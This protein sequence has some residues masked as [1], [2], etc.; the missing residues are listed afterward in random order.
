VHGP[1]QVSA[2]ARECCREHERGSACARC[3][4]RDGP[5]SLV[6]SIRDAGSTQWGLWPRCPLPTPGRPPS[7]PCRTVR[8][9]RNCPIGHVRQCR[10]SRACARGWH[11]MH[12]RRA[13]HAV[14][15]VG[16]LRPVVARWCAPEEP[17][18]VPDR[19][20]PSSPMVLP[21]RDPA[22]PR[23]APADLAFHLNPAWRTPPPPPSRPRLA[24]RRARRARPRGPCS[25]A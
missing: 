9:A 17:L 6:D 21:C 2:H 14:D 7:S 8:P 11:R 16:P 12:G 24:A 22:S 20:A 13:H 3:E 18:V 10:V 19:Q 1:C 15:I 4:M 23:L 5:C 25:G